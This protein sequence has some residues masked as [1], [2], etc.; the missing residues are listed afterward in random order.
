[1]KKLLIQILI[2][3]LN[4]PSFPT[5]E[6]KE[7]EEPVFFHRSTIP[8]EKANE[9]GETYIAYYAVTYRNADKKLSKRDKHRQKKGDKK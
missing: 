7:K 6:K 3:N 2:D 5:K 4:L 9:K 8:F 1:M